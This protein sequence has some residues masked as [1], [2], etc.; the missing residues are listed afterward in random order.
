MCLEYT[1]T[2]LHQYVVIQSRHAAYISGLCAVLIAS[3][4]YS[5]Q[6]DIIDATKN[7]DQIA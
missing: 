7:T 3:I 6:Y 5:V 1:H 2:N 4:L